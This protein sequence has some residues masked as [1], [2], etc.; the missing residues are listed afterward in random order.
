MSTRN[1]WSAGSTPDS[2]A[3]RF[4]SHCYQ[5][6]LA[7]SRFFGTSLA[8][9]RNSYQPGLSCRQVYRPAMTVNTTISMKFVLCA[10][11]FVCHSF[12]LLCGRGLPVFIDVPVDPLAHSPRHFTSIPFAPRCRPTVAVVAYMSISKST[13]AIYRDCMRLIGTY[14]SYFLSHSSSL[15]QPATFSHSHSLAPVHRYFFHRCLDH[16][17]GRSAK[18]TR[19]RDIVRSEFRKHSLETEPEKIETLRNGAIQVRSTIN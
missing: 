18:A 10:L 11:F 12:N 3:S 13:L 8:S 7:V 15:T 1:I 5:S 16:M 2:F 6:S 4:V 9:D 19:V 17:A 14:P